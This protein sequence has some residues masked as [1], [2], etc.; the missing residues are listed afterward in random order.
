[1]PWPHCTQP[2][3]K[4]SAARATAE[5]WLFTS[6]KVPSLQ[7]PCER[8]VET[9][10]GGPSEAYPGKVTES[11]PWG[12]GSSTASPQ[13]QELK[14]LLSLPLLSPLF[15]RQGLEE[16]EFLSKGPSPPWE[17]QTPLLPN[18]VSQTG[19]YWE[20]RSVCLQLCI[21]LKAPVKPDVDSKG[22][23]GTHPL[24]EV[25]PVIVLSRVPKPTP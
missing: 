6:P 23:S 15:E 5:P 8:G 13:T 1:M 2:L 10:L 12:Q 16:L 24:A 14:T 11:L 7:A 9:G 17:P 22:T 3:G 20:D 21:I 4:G 25:D 19:R 18:L